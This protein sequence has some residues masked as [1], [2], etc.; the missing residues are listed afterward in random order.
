MAERWGRQT[1]ALISPPEAEEEVDYITLLP[2]AIIHHIFSFL[3][4]KDVVK[5]SVLSRQWHFA[6]TSTPCIDLSLLSEGVVPSISRALRLC[7]ATKVDRF[8]FDP[9]MS[10]LYIPTEFDRWFHFAVV[11]KVEEAFLGFGHWYNVIPRFLCNCASLV[12][13]HV[14]TY[15]NNGIMRILSGC[16]VLESLTFRLSYGP[17]DVQIDSR[18]LQE[19][20][21]EAFHTLSLDISAP[22]LLS[23]CLTGRFSLIGFRLNGASSLAEAE[24]HFDKANCFFRLLL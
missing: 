14:F 20:V 10:D 1:P 16:P 24:L 19:L 6:W 3:P 21:I 5:A 4:Y 7:T 2:D 8:H 9:S 15:Y 18:C 23:L 13:L 22:N 12:S 11:R 17:C